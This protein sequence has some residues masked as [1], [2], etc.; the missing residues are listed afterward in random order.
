MPLAIELAAAWLNML[1]V[2][3]IAAELGHSLDLLESELRDVPDRHR[4][5]RLVF[6]RSWR[7][8]RTWPQ[9]GHP[10][11]RWS[12]AWTGRPRERSCHGIRKWPCSWP[13]AL[14]RANATQTTLAVPPGC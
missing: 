3:E 12:C 10:R 7:I 4:S 1:S 14:L 5:M 6:D 13:P 2:A 9:P 11:N 8:A